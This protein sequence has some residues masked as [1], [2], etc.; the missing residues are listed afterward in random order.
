MGEAIR[1]LYVDDDEHVLAA[2]SEYLDHVDSD[3]EVKTET[4]PER[5]IDR[6]ST[7]DVDCLVSDYRMSGMDGLEFLRAVRAEFE[8]LPFIF[9]TGKGSESVASEAISNDATD[10]VQKS[11]N[12]DYELLRKRIRVAVERHRERVSY[13]ELFENVDVG[14]VVRDIDSYEIREVNDAYCELLGYDSAHIR[15][16]NLWGLTADEAGY[17]EAR[18]RE[19]LDIAVSEG[20]YAGDWPFETSDGSVRWATVSHRLSDIRGARRILTTVQ[21]ITTQKRR[22]RELE[23]RNT[24]FE[25]AERLANIGAWEAD[26]VADEGWW[27]SEVS[28]IYG[29]APDYEPAVGEGIEYFHPEDRETIREAFENLVERGES[30]ELELRIVDTTGEQKWVHLR[31]EPV[32][33]GDTVVRARGT[34]Q[35]VT[36]RKEYEQ[37]LKEQ[38]DNLETLNEMVRHDIR[39]DLQL[40]LAYLE[41]LEPHVDEDGEEY[42]SRALESAQTAVALT[43]TARDLSEAMLQT[44]AKQEPVDLWST[45]QQ[46]VDEV[47]S[48][49]GDAE[50]SVERDG[51]RC[52]VRAND[53][54]ASVFRNILKNAIEHNDKDVPRIDVSVTE[55][56]DSVTVRIGDNG[57][58]IP[59]DQKEDI[60]VKGEKGLDSAGSGIGLY[61]VETLVDQYGGDVWVEDNEPTGA[62]FAVEL[63]RVGSDDR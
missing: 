53:M 10:Y 22:E 21:D 43:K 39:N 15:E 18:A 38:R 47:D 56:D 46:Q 4:D 3:L 13:R 62:I 50:I 19:T 7:E 20:S 27:S 17:D 59:D 5:A 60:F 6:L 1:V 42:R 44:D 41:T 32:R 63:P 36:E 25:Q 57:P 28:R 49:N 54:L 16:H 9:F 23:R 35:D 37:R 24:L 40:V 51:I 55:S 52:Q 26:L 2:V 31:G 58:G 33:K 29:L 48:A 14:V 11:S 45:L 61:L 8:S 34:I 12:G 30:Y